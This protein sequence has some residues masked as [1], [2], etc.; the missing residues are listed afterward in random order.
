[1]SFEPREYPFLPNQEEIYYNDLYPSLK[2][3]YSSLPNSL[4]EDALVFSQ[5]TII[6]KSSEDFSASKS[7]TFE[8]EVFKNNVNYF[9][10]ATITSEDSLTMNE[11]KKIGDKINALD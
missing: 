4:N 10:F 9:N 2:N 5:D 7:P 8:L 3:K 6:S 1:M 11:L